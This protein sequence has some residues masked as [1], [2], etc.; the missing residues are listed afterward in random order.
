MR[1]AVVQ[2]GARR[3]NRTIFRVVD[4]DAKVEGAIA[5]LEGVCG[6]FSDPATGIILTAPVLRVVGLKGQREEQQ[7]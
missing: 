4:D 6:D 3:E 1:N 2:A 5:L 7:E